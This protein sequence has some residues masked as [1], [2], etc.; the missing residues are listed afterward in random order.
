M[1]LPQSHR[2]DFQPSMTAKQKY[3]FSCF[4]IQGT[5]SFAVSLFSYYLYFLTQKRFGF[6]DKNNLALAAVLGIVT[7]LAAWQGGKFAERR[8]RFAALKLGFVVMIFALLIGSQ[9]DSAAGLILSAALMAVGGTCLWPA[10]EALVSEGENVAGIQRA[11]GIYNVSWAATNAL[12]LFCGG[13]LVEKFGYK[14]IFYIP[15][16]L[17]VAMLAWTF[18]LEKFADQFPHAKISKDDSA[19]PEP[20]RPSPARAKAFLKMAWLANPLAYV[21]IQTLTAVLPGIAL[22]FHLSPMI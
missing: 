8:G 3:K 11:V 20:N 2:G 7:A 18:A 22:K 16:V 13:T 5:S 15:F 10:L 21:A 1:V 6:D 17:S 14:S 12:G 9:F 19:P 4:T